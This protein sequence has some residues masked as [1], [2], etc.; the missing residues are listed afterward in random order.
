MSKKVFWGEKTIRKKYQVVFEKLR[1]YV[2][3]IEKKPTPS[4]GENFLKNIIFY[5]FLSFSQ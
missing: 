5:N 2:Q 1:I 4:F 3:K